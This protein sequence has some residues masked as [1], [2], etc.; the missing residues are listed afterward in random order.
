M[1]KSGLLNLL[2]IHEKSKENLKQ[3]YPSENVIGASI[4]IAQKILLKNQM[5]KKNIFI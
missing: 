3:E 1:L 5:E 2:F 4:D